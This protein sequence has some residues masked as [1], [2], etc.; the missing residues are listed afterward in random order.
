MYF[1]AR[2]SIEGLRDLVAFALQHYMMLRGDNV[3]WLEFADLSC[4]TLPEF[5]GPSPCTILV[6]QLRRGKTNQMGRLNYS[7]FTRARRED[8]CAVGNLALY[9]FAR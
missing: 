3:R 6:F 1:E 9:F 7:A 4:E 2:N 8:V 5:E